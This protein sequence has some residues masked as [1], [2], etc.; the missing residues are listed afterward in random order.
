MTCSHW[1]TSKSS[2]AHVDVKNSQGIIIIIIIIIRRRR[3]RMQKTSSMGIEEEQF[4]GKSYL[5]EIVQET[6]ISTY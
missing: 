1:S 6:K 4:G 5:L 3:R 2:S